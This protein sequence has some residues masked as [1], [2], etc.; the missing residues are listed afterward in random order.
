MPLV[1]L[2]GNGEADK[3]R[4]NVNN[5]LNKQ[6]SATRSGFG[7]WFAY[8]SK[9]TPEIHSLQQDLLQALDIHHAARTHRYHGTK[10]WV[11]ER[12]FDGGILA[13]PS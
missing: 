6:C 11:E 3:K 1:V 10:I 5:D 9:D 7:P 8:L 13:R 12:H 2:F 4:K